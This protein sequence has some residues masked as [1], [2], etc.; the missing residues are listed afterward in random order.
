MIIWKP[1]GNYKKLLEIFCNMRDRDLLQIT[2]DYELDGAMFYELEPAIAKPD[3][4]LR[5]LSYLLRT[6][7]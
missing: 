1:E 7:L 3:L 5:Y 6:C 4:F 2:Q